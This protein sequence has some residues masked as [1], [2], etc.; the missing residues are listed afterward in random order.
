MNVSAYLESHGWHRS[1]EPAML[2]GE[3]GASSDTVGYC[4]KSARWSGPF[5]LNHHF[6]FHAV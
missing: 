2:V 1:D 4:E 5:D 6:R 3:C